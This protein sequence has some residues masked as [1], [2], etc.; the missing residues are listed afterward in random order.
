MSRTLNFVLG[1]GLV[2]AA[3]FS[4][5]TPYVIRVLFTPPVSFGINCEPAADWSMAKL[6]AAEIVGLLVGMGGGLAIALMRKKRDDET[7]PAN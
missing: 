6:H 3:L 4:F 2:G 7:V 5:I 1:L